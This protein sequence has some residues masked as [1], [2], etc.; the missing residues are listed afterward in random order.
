MRIC[1]G[2][3]L[4]LFSQATLFPLRKRWSFLPA[5]CNRHPEKRTWMW[6]ARRPSTPGRLKRQNRSE[7]RRVG[8]ERRARRGRGSGG[9]ERG[10]QRRRRGSGRSRTEERADAGLWTESQST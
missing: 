2:C 3:V 1:G 5:G 10:R 7:E 9:E 4:S 6:V 8:K